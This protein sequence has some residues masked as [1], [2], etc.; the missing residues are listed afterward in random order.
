MERSPHPRAGTCADSAPEASN[1]LDRDRVVSGADGARGRRL[2][3]RGRARGRS[4]SAPG[5]ARPGPA[6]GG[7]GGSRLAS[8]STPSARASG[9]RTPLAPKV[10]AS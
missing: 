2:R 6:R 4:A 9:A 1:R 10:R 7:R 8:P 3:H 5:L